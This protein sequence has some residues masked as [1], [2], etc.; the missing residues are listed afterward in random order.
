MGAH[1]NPKDAINAAKEAEVELILAGGKIREPYFSKEIKPLIDGDKIKYL[2][3]VY[4]KTKINLLK[5]AKALLFPI[6]WPEPFGLVMIEA[7][8]CGT[9]IIAY[10]NGAV[11]EIVEDKKTGFI[12]KNISEMVKA[13]KKID[14][15]D[16]KKCRE[17]VE[18]KFSIEKM[19][20]E[21][22]K[23]SFKVLNYLK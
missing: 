11:P 1:K 2:G 23:I 8:A 14:R 16:R 19:I 12:V 22:E 21:Y 7:M 3:E 20:N 13:I 15:I 5:N 9:P 6:K 4:G 10:P 18:E 17:K